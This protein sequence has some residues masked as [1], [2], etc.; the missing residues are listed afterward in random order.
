MSLV[1]DAQLHCDTDQCKEVADPNVRE[2]AFAHYAITYVLSNNDSGVTEKDFC[3]NHAPEVER[4]LVS[5]G[6]LPDHPDVP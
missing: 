2:S 4:V 3:P 5:L 6:L 1:T